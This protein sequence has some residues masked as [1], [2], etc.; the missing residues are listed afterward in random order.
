MGQYKDY[1]RL[2]LE[3]RRH[4]TTH[5]GSRSSAS[6]NWPQ[7]SMEIHIESRTLKARLGNCCSPVHGMYVTMIGL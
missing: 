1:V 6:L 5:P 3:S 4:Y 2:R 7:L